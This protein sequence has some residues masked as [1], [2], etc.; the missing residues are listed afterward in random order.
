MSYNL[1]GWNAMGQNRGSRAPIL[2]DRINSANPDIVGTQEN[3]D[4]WWVARETGLSVVNSNAAGLAILYKSSVL[5]VVNDGSFALAEMDQWGLRMVIWAEFEHI[6]TK[7]RFTHYNTHFCVCSSSKLL[8]SAKRVANK[9]S[10]R[11][12]SAVLTGDLNTSGS[13]IRYLTGDTV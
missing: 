1:Y 7:G 6:A 8:G 4:R 9:M 11:G 10:E 3:T 12:G 2:W 5:R 13:V